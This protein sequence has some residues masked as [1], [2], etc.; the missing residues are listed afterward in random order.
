[1]K[2]SDEKDKEKRKNSRKIKRK[3]EKGDKLRRK[4]LIEGMRSRTRNKRK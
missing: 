4:K 1:M 2:P 3:V